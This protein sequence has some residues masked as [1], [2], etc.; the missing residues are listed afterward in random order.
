MQRLHFSSICPSMKRAIRLPQAQRKCVCASGPPHSWQVAL[1]RESF[2][3]D[4]ELRMTL[5]Q[6]MLIFKFKLEVSFYE[7]SAR[8]TPASAAGRPG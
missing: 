2:G 5:P 4:I 7:G 8:A 1:G 3:L 6:S